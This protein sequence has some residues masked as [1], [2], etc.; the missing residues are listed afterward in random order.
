VSSNDEF[1]ILVQALANSSNANLLSTPSITTL[2]NAPA[3][4]VVGQNVPFRTG[5][6]GTIGGSRDPFTTIEREDVG[7]TLQVAPQVHDGDVVRLTVS[8]EVSS[9]ANAAVLGAADLITNRRSIE[10]TV[11]ADDGETIVLGGLISNDQI[12]TESE[13]PV[14]GDIPVAGRLF[15]SEFETQTKRTL[16]VF[17]RPTILRD[18]EDSIAAA[19]A[20]LTL[21]NGAPDAMEKYRDTLLAPAVPGMRLEIEGVY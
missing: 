8:Q 18:R 17:L 4:I 6:Y 7:L 15:S 1:G 16:F 9:L 10:T 20:R 3:E 19:Q 11:L 14:L 12:T 2:D 13:V 5:T 21:V